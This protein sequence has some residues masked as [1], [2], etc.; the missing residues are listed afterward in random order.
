VNSIIS[1]RP[2]GVELESHPVLSGN[3]IVDI[4]KNN[5]RRQVI[6]T[7]WKQ[8]FSNDFWHV[9]TD[10]TCG[11]GKLKG[12]EIAS[13]KAC[14]YKELIEICKVSKALRKGGLKCGE[15]CGFH[16]H[17]DISDFSIE[18]AAVLLAYWVKIEKIVLKSVPYFR[19]KNKY[20]RSISSK[21]KSKNKKWN[22]LDFWNC[23]KPKDKSIHLNKDKRVTMNLV[24]YVTFIEDPSLFHGRSTAE[25]RF[26][27]GTFNERDIRNWVVF[28][29]N[30]VDNIKNKQMPEDLVCVSKIDELLGICGIKNEKNKKW[31]FQRISV[32]DTEKKWK[33]YQKKAKF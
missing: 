26:P 32:F 21:I 9:K 30:F 20:C 27:D 33:N 19:T 17:V 12:W 15:D 29:V 7:K 16:V 31:F 1:F 11:G 22:A 4:V 8:T 5:S 28:F 13:F 6:K 10:S 14:G 3:E 23:H 24:N 18:Q 2:F 25:F